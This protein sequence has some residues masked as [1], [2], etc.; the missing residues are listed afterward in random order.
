[1]HAQVETAILQAAQ[2]RFDF[3]IGASIP[4]PSCAERIPNSKVSADQTL[5]GSSMPCHLPE[6]DLERK[7]CEIAVQE[8]APNRTTSLI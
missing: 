8:C 7:N 5:K 2:L 3:F 4:N 6:K 1:M